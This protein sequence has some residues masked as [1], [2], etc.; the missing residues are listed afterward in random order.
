M[1]VAGELF[2]LPTPSGLLAL[3]ASITSESASGS[4]ERVPTPVASDSTGG[5][6]SAGRQGGLNLKTYVH[7]VPAPN[8]PNG[9]RST[10]HVTDWRGNS[11]Y[12]NGKKVQVGLESAVH[13]LPTP[14]V[15]GNNNKLGASEKSGDGLA[16]AVRRLSTPTCQDAKNNGAT[17]QR[18]R[19]TPPL[20]TQIGGPLN[21]PWVEWL[22]GW[23]I[24][25]TDLNA[26]A[27]DSFQQWCASHGKF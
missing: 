8:V 16:T 18:E 9:G 7:R 10:E 11:A 17:S 2:P 21:P 15:S 4:S 22:M 14:T 23:P 25:W 24:G 5:E 1:I 6:A 13:R 3:R 12:H 26:P 20:N 19:N 27:T